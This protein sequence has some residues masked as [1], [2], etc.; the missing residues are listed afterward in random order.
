MARSRILDILKTM[1][2]LAAATE[3]RGR[4]HPAYHSD[5]V[6]GSRI[7]QFLH[8]SRK[9]EEEAAM[10]R[11]EQL[12]SNLLRSNLPPCLHGLPAQKD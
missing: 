7:H 5:Y 8:C 10:A 2:V 9:R 1:A 12:R 6:P 11:A 4:R 3:G